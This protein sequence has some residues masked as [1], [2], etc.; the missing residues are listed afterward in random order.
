MNSPVCMEF[1]FTH[2]LLF[3]K[4]G[5]PKTKTKYPSIT[6]QNSSIKTF[7]LI[8]V[9]FELCTPFIWWRICRKR[10]KIMCV[11]WGHYIVVMQF[12]WLSSTF[13]LLSC[14]QNASRIFTFGVQ[15]ILLPVLKKQRTNL[16]SHNERKILPNLTFDSPS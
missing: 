10:N 8:K 11:L 15:Q 2:F 3:I 9:C 7:F 4:F 13:Q 1:S 6:G 14:G 5:I 16:Y 12:L